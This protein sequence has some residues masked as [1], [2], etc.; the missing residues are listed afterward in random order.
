L[1]GYITRILETTNFRQLVNKLSELNRYCSQQLKARASRRKAGK[2]TADEEPIPPM[3]E[4]QN[5]PQN[6][7]ELCFLG[8]L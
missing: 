6:L 1:S 3:P 8:F 5:P 2:K 4:T 7:S